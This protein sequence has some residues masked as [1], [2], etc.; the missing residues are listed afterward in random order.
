M[1]EYED[2]Y[3]KRFTLQKGMNHI[4][5]KMDSLITS[6]TKRKMDLADIDK[7]LFFMY[8]PVEKVVLYVDYIRLE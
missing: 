8:K 4:K 6:D 5:I 2:R 7:F 3:N 1:T